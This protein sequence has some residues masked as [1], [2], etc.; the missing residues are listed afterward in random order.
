MEKNESYDI[1][2]TCL[3]ILMTSAEAKLNY[4]ISIHQTACKNK[5]K[6]FKS[7]SNHK[8]KFITFLFDHEKL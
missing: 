5:V 3:L 4:N 6:P 1:L 7:I 2:I 8:V